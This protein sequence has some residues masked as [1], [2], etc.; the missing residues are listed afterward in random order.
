[1]PRV[2]A[3]TRALTIFNSNPILAQTSK[4]GRDLF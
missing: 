2:D 3:E 1:M 4:S